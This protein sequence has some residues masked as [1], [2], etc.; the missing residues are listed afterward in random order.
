MLSLS[1]LLLTVDCFSC[2][3][4][5]VSFFNQKSNIINTVKKKKKVNSH[6]LQKRASCYWASSHSQCLGRVK[7]IRSW[8]T[9]GLL[10]QLL[11]GLVLTATMSSK[12]SSVTLHLRQGLA[13][14]LESFSST[15]SFHF[16]GLK[17]P[18]HT[19]ALLPMINYCLSVIHLAPGQKAYECFFRLNHRNTQRLY[20]AGLLGKAAFPIQDLRHSQYIEVSEE[21]YSQGL[22]LPL[23]R[24]ALTQIC[25]PRPGASIQ[26]FPYLGHLQKAFLHLP[27]SRPL[28]WSVVGGQEP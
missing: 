21:S 6:F 1:L 18:P 17:I 25:I 4:S 15:L 2:F 23:A 8:A 24:K 28:Y 19:I 20:P 3:V 10:C 16:V 13:V 22:R 7:L 27:L 11:L 26:N 14:F 5:F 9:F 12:S